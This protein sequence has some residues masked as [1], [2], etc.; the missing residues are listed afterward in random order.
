MPILVEYNTNNLFTK[1][2]M[3][4]MSEELKFILFHKRK[5]DTIKNIGTAEL[6]NS[7]IILLSQSG[8]K[9]PIFV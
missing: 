5:E 7:P 4:P 3:T 2:L 9:A 1:C 6:L 8:K